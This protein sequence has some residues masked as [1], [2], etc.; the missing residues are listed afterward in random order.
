MGGNFNIQHS[1][2]FRHDVEGD[3]CVLFMCMDGMNPTQN[4]VL[5]MKKKRMSAICIFDLE[6][7]AAPEKKVCN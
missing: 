4:V 1:K 5:E 2:I 6:L 3:V 7:L